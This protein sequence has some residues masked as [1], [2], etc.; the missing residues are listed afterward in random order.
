MVAFESH[1]TKKSPFKKGGF[2]GFC[3][4]DRVNA[5]RPYGFALQGRILYL[6]G[7]GMS[8]YF[9]FAADLPVSPEQ[10]ECHSSLHI[11]VIVNVQM[12]PE[13]VLLLLPLPRGRGLTI[14]FTP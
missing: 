1:T 5:I 14:Q 13:G 7:C 6:P 3:A 12:E 8:G 9:L 4:V 2:R 10:G 11:G